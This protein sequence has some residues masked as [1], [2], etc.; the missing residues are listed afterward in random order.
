MNVALFE[1]TESGMHV[2][3]AKSKVSSVQFMP[4]RKK[5]MIRVWVDGLP[6]PLVVV[7][8]NDSAETKLEEIKRLVGWSF[9]PNGERT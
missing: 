1:W 9:T 2:T 4:D 8:P 6:W 7:V 3:V 5:T